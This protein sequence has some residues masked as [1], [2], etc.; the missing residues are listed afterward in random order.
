MIARLTGA[1]SLIIILC[2]VQIL[3][4]SPAS[5]QR[6]VR[7]SEIENTLRYFTNP[8]IESAGLDKNQIQ[9]HMILD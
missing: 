4:T 2:C 6:V 9:L 8:L 5:A 7:D 3:L 1:K